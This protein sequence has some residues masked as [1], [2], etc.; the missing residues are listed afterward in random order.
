M[1]SSPSGS[2]L[3]LKPIATISHK[4]IPYESEQ[5]AKLL[6]FALPPDSTGL[7]HPSLLA[8]DGSF[9]TGDLFEIAEG[10][11]LFRGRKEDWIIMNG[12]HICDTK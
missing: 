2:P 6:E 3:L 9:Y 11:Y 12:G 4:W 5:D 1:R 8:L 10:G 7:P